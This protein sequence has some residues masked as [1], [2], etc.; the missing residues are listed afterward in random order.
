MNGP[1]VMSL[2]AQK[3][4][5][6]KTT[7]AVNLAAQAEREGWRARVLDIDP[8]GSATAWA[9]ER[10]ADRPD[11]RTCV[12]RRLE[13]E[14]AEAAEDGTDA[15]F[16][17]T[18]PHAEGAA[19]AAARVADLVLV[20]CRPS[21]FDLAAAVATLELASI[22]GAPAAVALNGVPPR[23]GIAAEARAAL[24]GQGA[25]VL[26]ATVGHRAAVW[27]SQTRGL[28]V[29]EHEPGGRAAAEIRALWRELVR[30]ERPD[31]RRVPQLRLVRGGAAADAA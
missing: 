19:L 10:E 16:V 29:T 13:R 4:G 5:V 12:S 2:V 1:I 28:G 14:L 15:V 7:L 22:A 6:G 17:D 20:P 24:G 25:R 9:D 23:G 26:A 30:V 11:V 21:L 18:A 3:G 27:H 31:L 8:Q